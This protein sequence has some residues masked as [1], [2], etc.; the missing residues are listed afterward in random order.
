VPDSRTHADGSVAG[1]E[2]RHTFWGQGN[3][4]GQ[5]LLHQFALRIS[6]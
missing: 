2:A 4:V 1:R 6:V 5:S 3:V